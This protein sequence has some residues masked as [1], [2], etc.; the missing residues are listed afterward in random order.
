MKRTLKNLRAWRKQQDNNFFLWVTGL[1]AVVAM[2]LAMW[3]GMQQSIWFDE[4]YSIVTAKQQT[5]ELL[6]DVAVDT[7]PP[8]YYLLLKAWGETFNWSEFSLRGLSALF[9]GG[10]IIFAGAL[11]RRMFGA[12]PAVMALL[13]MVLAPMMMRY[14]FEIR[15]YAMA[16]FIGI[17][18]TYV[19]VRAYTT[20][21]KDALQFWILYAV[22]VALGMYTLYYLAFLWMAHL[23]WLLF[24]TWRA[25][26]RRDLYKAPW[27]LAYVGA[28][29]L[30]L[31]WLP[32]FIGQLGNNALAP[33]GEPMNVQ[34]ILGIVSFHFLYQPLWALNMPMTILFL[35]VLITLIGTSIRAWR[36]H[37]HRP[38]VAL[39]LCYF[40]VPIVILM[41]VS[42][43]RPMYVERYLSHV[44]IGVMMFT[45]VVVWLAEQHRPSQ[46]QRISIGM[47]ILV[48]I[49]GFGNLMLAGNFNFQRMQHPNLEQVASELSCKDGEAIVAEDPYLAI[50][51]MATK[52][53]CA[54]HFVSDTPDL[55]GGYAPL[56]HSEY[57]VTSPVGRIDGFDVVKYVYYNDSDVQFDEAT[58]IAENTTRLGNISIRTLSVE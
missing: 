34:N 1:V 58:Y 55:R 52:P 17:A 16:S 54:I 22:L 25:R 37:E 13:F 51:L 12:K 19:M 44:A 8:L 31:P 3:I 49:V 14:G 32:Q 40:A 15:M 50:E 23:V 43:L 11:V 45:G 33:I 57:R 29:V 56:A 36:M 21:R 53:T 9:Y 35:F 20:P 41:L 27:V 2:M 4:A 28:F 10:S 48:M 38:Y 30:F 7:H 24:M 46:W 5:S 39:L 6:G 18:A 42:F 26:R 47:V